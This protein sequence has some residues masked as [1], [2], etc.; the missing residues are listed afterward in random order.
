MKL[1]GSLC[2]LC[3]GGGARYLGLRALRR[4]IDTLRALSDAL[5]EMAE[6]I[7]QNR[8][9]LPRLLGR[10]ERSA[11]GDAAAFFRAAAA[12]VQQGRTLPEAWREAAG[13]MA[14]P[15]REMETLQSLSRPL[16]GDEQESCGAL[17][18]ARV[19]LSDAAEQRE[20]CRSETERRYTALCFS[21]AALA[22]I[23][24]I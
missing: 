7:R 8:T 5:G 6:E 22:I 3:A 13:A 14:L 24:L 12:L 2:L 19:R 11:R 20:S 15:P 9:P 23:L 18:L 10:M 4:E 17:R 16:C 21:G 1:V